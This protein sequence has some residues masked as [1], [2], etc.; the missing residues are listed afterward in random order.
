MLGTAHFQ[1]LFAFTLIPGALAALC[2]AMLVR[3]KPHEPQHNAGLASGMRN[4]P[5]PFYRYLVGIGVAGIG[6]FSKTLLILW[7][8]QALTPR[9][10]IQTAAEYAM[11]FYVG[12]NVV[13][14]VSCY[15]SGSL[16]DRFPKNYVLATG[17]ALAVIPAVALMLPS[18]SLVKFAIV[19][20]FSGVYM[21]VW[22]TV[23]NSTAATVLPKNLRGTGFGVLATVQGIG[24]L[25]SSIAVG[26]LWALH[27]SRGHGLCDRH[28]RRW[29]G[30][31]RRHTP[32]H[33]R[34]GGHAG[35]C[36]RLSGIHRLRPSRLNRF[37]PSGASNA[38]NFKKI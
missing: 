34:I 28:R 8:T 26:C 17:Y 3:E 36:E 7:A 16:A 35:K 20:G 2:I 5:A 9:L 4:L 33:R 1:W 23:E 14:T 30:N 18:I 38:S 22:E 11:L 24:D 6:D 21:G 25:I 32:R 12:Y 10:G 29:R 19:F 37:N 27:P 31:H 15:V 13:Y